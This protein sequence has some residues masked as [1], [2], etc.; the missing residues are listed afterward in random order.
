MNRKIATP[1]RLVGLA[2]AGILAFGSLAE[3]AMAYDSHHGGGGGG[4][5]HGGGR[6]GWGGR[7]GGGWGG[8][9]GWAGGYWGPPPLIYGNPGY[10]GYGYGYGYPPPLIYGPGVDL[11]LGIGGRVR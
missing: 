11:R 8:G 9:G 6:G 4:H 7:G 1:T 10:Y 3:P 5:W 2:V